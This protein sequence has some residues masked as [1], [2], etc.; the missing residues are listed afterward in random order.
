MYVEL[1]DFLYRTVFYVNTFIGINNSDSK[2][3][4]LNRV[5]WARLA[6]LSAESSK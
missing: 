3:C 5:G 4:E 2:T 1:N 6:D